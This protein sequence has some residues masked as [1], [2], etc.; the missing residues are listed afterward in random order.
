MRKWKILLIIFSLCILLGIFL[1]HHLGFIYI[2]PVPEYQVKTEPINIF[3]ICEEIKNGQS[4]ELCFSIAGDNDFEKGLALVTKTLGYSPE[5]YPW[6]DFPYYVSPRYDYFPGGVDGILKKGRNYNSGQWCKDI[7]S[8]YTPVEEDYYFCRAFLENPYF[9]G[10]IIY[11][12]G[13]SKGTCYQD[14]AF[15]WQDPSLCKKASYQ[16][17]CYFRLVL[18][19]L[20]E[21][22][23]KEKIQ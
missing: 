17:F 20:E 8:S 23:E 14:A 18:K 13:P 1:L 9:C 15:V 6:Y 19:Y 3:A 12:M 22:Q 11:S 4:Q 10:K 5:H 7:Y 21:I 16:D 2:F